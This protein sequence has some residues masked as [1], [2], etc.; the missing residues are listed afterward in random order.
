MKVYYSTTKKEAGVKAANS[1]ASLLKSKPDAV[2]G[3]ATGSSPIAMYDELAAMCERGEISFKDVKSINLDEYIGLDKEHDQSYAYFMKENLFGRVDINM[4]NT[5]LPNGLAKDYAAECKRYDELY[6]SLGG[7]DIQVLGIGHNGHIAFNEPSESFSKGTNAV[8]LKES[9]IK[10]NA[11]F[12]ASED[13]VPKMALSMGIDQI[14]KSKKI[15]LLADGEAKAE[16]LERA[17]FGD[18]TPSVPA[19]ALQLVRDVEVYGD[20]KSLAII[21]EKHPEALIY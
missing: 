8:T 15:I 20:E 6:V 9:T 12:F 16:I 18:I 3:L 7:T 17:L 10:A 5:N 11:R 4:A 1:I 13:E 21:K 19:S 14:T 2:L